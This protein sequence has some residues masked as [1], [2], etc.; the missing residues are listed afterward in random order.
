MLFTFG[1][2]QINT[3][4]RSITRNGDEIQFE[5]RVF[6]LLIYFCNHPEKAISRQELIEHVWNQRTVSDA[7][8]NRAVSEL[9]KLI[10]DEPNNPKWILTVSKVGYKLNVTPTSLSSSKLTKQP[11]Q[12]TNHSRSLTRYQWAILILTMCLVIMALLY[13]G[14]K[15]N[16]E[17]KLNISEIIPITTT[18]GIAFNP[19]PVTIENNVVY[20]Y[21]ANSNDFSQI[22]KKTINDQASAITADN[23]YYTDVVYGKKNQL[24]ASRFNNLVD[25]KCE[26]VSINLVDLEIT[27]LLECGQRAIVQ[28]AYN[29]NQRS[30]YFNNRASVNSPYSIY[31]Y[32]GNTGRVQQITLATQGHNGRGDYL[33]AISPNKTRLAIVEYS[34]S[35]NTVIKIQDLQTQEIVL[36]ITIDQAP[37]AISWLTDDTI[38]STNQNGVYSH[39]LTSNATAAIALDKD[40]GRITNGFEPSSFL[41]EKQ[42]IIANIYRRSL[43]STGKLTEA[44]THADS[45]SHTAKFAN[46]SQYFAYISDKSGTPNIYIGYEGKQDIATNFQPKITSINHLAWS[47]DDKYLAASINDSLYIYERAENQ[48]RAVAPKFNKVHFV[49]YANNQQILFS[50]E[51]EGSWQIWSLTLNDMKVEQ[52]SHSGGYSVQSDRAGLKILLTKFNHPGLYELNLHTMKEVIVLSDFKI[53]SWNRWQLIGEHLYFISDKQLIKYNLATKETQSIAE[54]SQNQPEHF[55]ISFDEQELIQT[56]IDESKSKIWLLKIHQD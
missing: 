27:P 33:L 7:A 3:Q 12:S 26:I 17:K 11:A 36:S 18:K 9:R 24:F 44:L 51:K 8:I 42:K 1:E 37:I 15:T 55:S 39:S 29:S 28:L 56:Q 43:V 25:R 48:W 5:P 38:I 35:K 46:L 30:L 32:H 50:A 41:V 16:S 4:E 45:V 47:P 34:P 21:K 49:H 52:V 40:L 13:F 54:F 31:A 23:Y 6:E 20:L 22:W 10:E 2:L 53:T 14:T 19:A